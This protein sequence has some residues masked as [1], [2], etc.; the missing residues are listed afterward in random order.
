MEHT[1]KFVI[2]CGVRKSFYCDAY[3]N[4]TTYKPT[5]VGYLC[6]FHKSIQKRLNAKKQTRTWAVA[7]TPTQKDSLYKYYKFPKENYEEVE[8]FEEN[9]QEWIEYS[10][11]SDSSDS[12]IDHCAKM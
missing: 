1:C 8:Y 5:T 4:K 3:V 6:P 12:A 9:N 11:S 7:V 2:Q 10:E